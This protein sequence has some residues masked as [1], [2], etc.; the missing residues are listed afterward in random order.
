MRIC[1]VE[2]KGSEAILV[3]I[4]V[5]DEAISLV[6]C[7]TRKIKYSES[8]EHQSARLFYDAICGFI[9]DQH[10]EHISV[11]QRA[12]KGQFAGGPVTFKMEALFQLNP[13]APTQLFSGPTIA[14]ATRRHDFQIPE[15]L[16]RYQAD[17]Y[18]TA[19]C[20]AVTHDAAR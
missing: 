6:A 7:Q 2:L 1:G 8:A 17:A 9:L 5:V 18:L 11:K 13:H 14:A 15:Q 16:N 12:Q 10:I 4:D 3:L 19:C 20:A